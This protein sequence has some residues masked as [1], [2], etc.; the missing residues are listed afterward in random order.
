ERGVGFE[1]G[2]FWRFLLRIFKFEKG[3]PAGPFFCLGANLGHTL[4]GFL[5]FG[6]W[7]VPLSGVGGQV[8]ELGWRSWVAFWA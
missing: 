5:F 7:V 4:V 8:Q 6:V 3:S 2:R 1:A